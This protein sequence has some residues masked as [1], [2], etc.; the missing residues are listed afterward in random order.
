MTALMVVDGPAPFRH[1]VLAR[2]QPP[3]VNRAQLGGHYLEIVLK[4]V[5]TVGGGLERGVKGVHHSWNDWSKGQRID[6]VGEVELVLGNEDV[7]VGVAL[8]MGHRAPC[9]H[10]K[11]SR[12]FPDRERT[13]DATRVPRPLVPLRSG[14]R[15]AH[16]RR[17]ERQ[18]SERAQVRGGSRR[19][20]R[21]LPL[22][23]L[24]LGRGE[25]EHDVFLYDVRHGHYAVTRHVYQ[26]SAQEPARRRY[27]HV[28]A[29][30]QFALHGCVY[31]IAVGRFCASV[32]EEF[33]Y[34][35]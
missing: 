13:V 31:R 35:E 18:L 2:V 1:R 14:H 33:G 34:N 20:G 26:V 15:A 9:R 11:V 19:V 28:D 10:V 6:A 22:E 30:L 12:H 16:A 3:Q 21:S 29:Q 32:V 5:V 25:L 4:D 17:Q 27:C 24:F 8:R 7:Q 23:P